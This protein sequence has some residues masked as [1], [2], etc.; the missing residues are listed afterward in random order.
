[1]ANQVASLGS[2]LG[3]QRSLVSAY[4]REAN[5]RYGYV[6][7][8]LCTATPEHLRIRNDVFSQLEKPHVEPPKSPVPPQEPPTEIE[9]PKSPEK[10]PQFRGKWMSWADHTKKKVPKIA[11]KTTKK[12]PAKPKNK[13]APKRA[14][15][16]QDEDDAMSNYEK[17]LRNKYHGYY[18]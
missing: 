16:V 14:K 8:D 15:K 6:L 13:K 11:I 1:M 4:Q 18:N 5:K 12:R 3:R 10:R 9:K 2:Q 17:Y 7:V